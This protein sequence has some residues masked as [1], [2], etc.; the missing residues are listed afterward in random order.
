M[1]DDVVYMTPSSQ[2]IPPILDDIIYSKPP[3]TSLHPI[4]VWKP[5]VLVL[6]PGGI[7]GLLHLGALFYFEE[8]NIISDVHTYVGVS[9][10]AVICLLLYIGCSINE[11]ITEAKMDNF[12]DDIANIKLEDIIGARTGILP[13]NAIR[14]RVESL[15]LK[16]MEGR[17]PTLK[18]LYAR[19]G[20][21]L[22]TVAVNVRSKKVEYISWVNHPDL[23]C[24]DAV[25]F[26][27]ALP[28]IFHRMLLGGV[29]YIDG[30]FGDPYPVRKHDTGKNNVLGM[31]IESKIDESDAPLSIGAYV[32]AVVSIPIA[33][34]RARSISES[35]SRCKHLRLETSSTSTLGLGMTP[36]ARTEMIT[37]GYKIA[38]TF[39][40]TLVIPDADARKE[41][42]LR[43]AFSEKKASDGEEIIPPDLLAS[44]K[45]L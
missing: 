40:S 21:T 16:K 24:V 26:S 2:P 7:K 9:I 34:L 17:I 3:S 6:G 31:Y 12:L 20:K 35:S 10:G 19:T 30:A 32:A 38:I 5:H 22:E 42:F 41:E 27:C 8:D 43:S 28:F 14:V 25:L 33:Q 15:V 11:I 23:P 39:A 45:P 4:K 36:Q 29:Q 1:S 18:E 37:D 13:M 44:I